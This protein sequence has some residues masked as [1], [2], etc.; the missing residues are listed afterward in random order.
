MLQSSMAGK[1]QGSRLYLPGTITAQHVRK[2]ES[3]IP[4]DGCETWWVRIG[5]GD[6][7]V[8]VLQPGH[9][10]PAEERDSLAQREPRVTQDPGELCSPTRAA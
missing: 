7:G 2:R 1:V 3:R 6:L 8:V 5:R 4:Q 10:A 9:A